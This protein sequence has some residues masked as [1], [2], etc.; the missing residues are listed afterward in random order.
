MSLTEYDNASKWVALFRQLPSW[1]KV[2]IIFCV[3]AAL[4]IWLYAKYGTI[5]E[6]KKNN[7]DLNQKLAQANSEISTLRDR[8]DELHRENLHLKE[9]NDAIQKTAEQ[10]HPDLDTVAAIAKLAEDLKTVRSLATQDAYK[11]L[12]AQKKKEL[13]DKLQALLGQYTSFTHTVTIL[14]QPGNSS[15]VK[16]AHDLKQYLEEAGFDVESPAVL[17]VSMGIRLPNIS[18]QLHPDD[19]EF[20]E[21]FI[22]AVSPLYIDE[23]FEVSTKEKISRGCPEVVINGDPIFT[24]LGV[25]KFR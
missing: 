14:C 10:L 11:P 2:L 15:R 1:L 24:E 4:S 18:I 9:I 21:Q 8:K 17:G 19:G 20:S 16:V 25:V 12:A 23:K 7:A 5:Q 6:L 13:I 22:A 3:V